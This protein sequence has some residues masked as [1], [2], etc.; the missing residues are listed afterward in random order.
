MKSGRTHLAGFIGAYGGGYR[1]NRHE[2]Y[3][4]IGIQQAFTGQGLGRLLFETVEA[5]GAQHDIHRYKLTVMCHNSRAVRL[6]QK[7]GYQ[8]EGLK[9]DSLLVNGHYVDEYYM[10]KIAKGY[11]NM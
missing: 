2:V 6:Y 9:K 3:I 4:V 11:G 8:I 7:L 10:A 1:R 5:W